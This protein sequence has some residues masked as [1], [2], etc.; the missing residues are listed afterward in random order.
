[1]EKTSDKESFP[2]AALDCPINY[3]WTKNQWRVLAR[4]LKEMKEF[5]ERRINT[6]DSH[7][8]YKPPFIIVRGPKGAGKT[9]MLE[10]IVKIIASINSRERSQVTGKELRVIVT[11]QGNFVTGTKLISVLRE[12]KLKSYLNEKIRICE[13]D[14]LSETEPRHVDV[15]LIDEFLSKNTIYVHEQLTSKDLPMVVS[16]SAWDGPDPARTSIHNY[17]TVLDGPE[18]DLGSDSLRAH[19]DLI[20]TAEKELRYIHANLDEGASQ[21]IRKLNNSE[22]ISQP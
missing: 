9:I 1:M 2:T 17:F 11:A 13:V 12:E 20:D 22:A 21:L 5:M 14:E 10:E 15:L 3:L 8:A 4:I 18:S 16:F 6:R 7:D 19:P